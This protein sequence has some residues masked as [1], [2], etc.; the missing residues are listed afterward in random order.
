[1]AALRSRKMHRAPIGRN[2][3]SSH[4]DTESIHMRDWISDLLIFSAGIA[5]GILITKLQ[6]YFRAAEKHRT[7]LIAARARILAGIKEKHDEEIL[8]E[9]FRTTEAIRSELSRSAQLLHKTLLTVKEPSK[10]Q[11]KD[12]HQSLVSLSPIVEPN[13]SNS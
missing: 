11:S 10:D 5:G 9:A 4:S 2:Y 3:R 8:D 12:E 7:A 1:M 13:R 6:P